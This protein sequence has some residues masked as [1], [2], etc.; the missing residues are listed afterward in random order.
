LNELNRSVG[1]RDAYPFLLNEPVAEKLGMVDRVIDLL[2]RH[3]R[4]WRPA[5]A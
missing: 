5:A 4:P 3:G 1:K 2:S